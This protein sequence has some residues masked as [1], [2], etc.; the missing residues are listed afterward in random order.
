MT[1]RIAIIGAGLGGLA[2]ASFLRMQGHEVTIFERGA[3]ARPTG[4]GLL[5]QPAG[6]AVLSHLGLDE[7]IA[8]KGARIEGLHGET[9]AGTTLIDLQYKDLS[10]KLFGVGI[11]RGSL[12]DALYE[13]AMDLGAKLVTGCDIVSA[14]LKDGK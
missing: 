9:T 4:A 5:V 14:E 12:F 7:T 11:H 2:A 6:L 10:P 13:K 8:A 1:Y 3:E